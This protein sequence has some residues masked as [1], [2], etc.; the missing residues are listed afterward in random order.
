MGYCSRW[1]R[2]RDGLFLQPEEVYKKIDPCRNRGRN[3]N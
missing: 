3:Q 2:C 1:S